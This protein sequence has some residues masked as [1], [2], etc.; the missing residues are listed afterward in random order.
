MSSDLIP[1][2]PRAMDRFYRAQGA[3]LRLVMEGE[4]TQQQELLATEN[5]PVRSPRDVMAVMQP[6]AEREVAEV[7]WVLALDSQHRLIGNAP[8]EVTRGILNSSLVHPREVFR[9]GIVAGA[10]ALKAKRL[11]ANAWYEPR[12]AA[13]SRCA[14]HWFYHAAVSHDAPEFIERLTQML[15]Q[16]DGELAKTR[17]HIPDWTPEG[18]REHLRERL[19]ETIQ[20]HAEDEERARLTRLASV[21]YARG[22]LDRTPCLRCGATVGLFPER[23]WCIVCDFVISDPF[24]WNA[25]VAPKGYGHP[26]APPRFSGWDEY[27]GPAWIDV[28]ED[29]HFNCKDC[30]GRCNRHG[31]CIACLDRE[32]ASRPPERIKRPKSPRKKSASTQQPETLL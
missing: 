27:A 6:L 21:G 5:T 30:G 22:T 14:P 18:E 13:L 17:S 3:H 20:R 10:A 32:R 2:S 9:A 19:A 15:R 4:P 8:I 29:P 24:A 28:G 23:P 26:A 7:F 12:P 31:V 1:T 25:P 11:A 16:S